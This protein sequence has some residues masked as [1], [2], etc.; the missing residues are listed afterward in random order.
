MMEVPSPEELDWSSKDWDGTEAKAREQN[1]SLIDFNEPKPQTNIDQNTDIDEVAFSKLQIGQNSLK[2]EPR[3]V[4]NLLIPPP[5]P[6]TKTPGDTTGNTYG[7]KLSKV[8]KRL[9]KEE[10]KYNLYGKVYVGQ[11]SEEEESDT[12]LDH[13]TYS[14][15]A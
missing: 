15:F 10:E 3:E 13:S 4:T 7:E 9:Q 11:L 2:K 5:P 8:E 1:D 6:V 12:H 14:Y